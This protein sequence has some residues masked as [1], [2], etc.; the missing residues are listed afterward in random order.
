M[1]RN[2][3]LCDPDATDRI[4]VSVNTC[5]VG[6]CCAILS[7]V[8]HIVLTCGP[9][10]SAFADWGWRG[11]HGSGHAE[12]GKVPTHWSADKGVLWRTAVPGRGHSSPVVAANKI[13]LTTADDEAGKQAILCFDVQTG[14]QLWEKTCFED[15][16]LPENHPKNTNAS[17]SVAI[18]GDRGFAVFCNDNTTHVTC[19]DFDGNVQWQKSVG[20]WVPTRYQFGF[21][22]TPICYQGRVIVTSE[23]ETESFIKAMDVKTGENVWAI[24]RPAFTSYSTPVICKTAGRMQLLICGGKTV[25]GYDPETGAQL[26]ST[27]AEWVVSCGTMVWM[28]GGSTVYASGGYPDQ[29]T[30][31]ISADGSAEVLWENGVKCYEQSLIVVDDCVYG[32]AEGGVLYCWDAQSGETLWRKRLGGP[33]SASPVYAN[34]L[35]YVSSEKGITWVIRPSRESCEILAENQLEE[36]M[37]ASIAVDGN[38]LIL[39]VADHDTGERQEYLYCLGT[40]P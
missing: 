14:K 31:A 21:G 10:H 25:E 13:F 40:A 7:L 3:K 6:A 30:L 5:G 36:E 26:W 18:S 32:Y 15:V 24:Q 11:P 23:S 38:H 12:A 19:F 39:R 8:A 20:R 33:E 1:T 4:H 2:A 16:E 29:Q 9:V 27:D 34:G 37:F 28:P 17:P 35:L 22:Q